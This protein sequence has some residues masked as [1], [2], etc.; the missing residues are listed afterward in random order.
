ME[1]AWRCDESQPRA[2]AAAMYVRS[3]TIERKGLSLADGRLIIFTASVDIPKLWLYR[4][5]AHECLLYDGTNET[6]N[7]TE[8]TSNEWED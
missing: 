3:E 2:L 4:E 7:S 5:D 8:D 6:I 1:P